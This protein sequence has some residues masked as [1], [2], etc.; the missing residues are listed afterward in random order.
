MR[1]MK[2]HHPRPTDREPTAP[3]VVWALFAV[4]ITAACQTPP[5]D[6]HG[7]AASATSAVTAP[8]PAQ[9]ETAASSPTSSTSA[10]DST[11]PSPEVP[12]CKAL[13]RK[14]TES[15]GLG[16]DEQLQMHAEDGYV[17]LLSYLDVM[18]RVRWSRISRSGGQLEQIAEV[19]R[20]GLPST[21]TSRDGAAYYTQSG[22]LFK[23]GPE[24]GASQ[25]LSESAHSPPALY[26]DHLFFVECDKKGKADYLQE[27]PVTGGPARTLAE[28]AHPPGK[29]CEYPSLVADAR[30]VIVADWKGQRVVAVSRK[31]GSQRTLLTKR[32]FPQ[33]LILEDNAVTLLSSRGLERIARDG[34]ATVELLDSEQAAAPF[35]HVTL[36]NGEYWVADWIPYM[37][38][39]HL[40]RL[41]YAGGKAQSVV[42]F[43][44]ASPVDSS[45]TDRFLAGFAVDDECVYWARTRSGGKKAELFARGK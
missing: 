24:L 16:P 33:S 10:A 41:P 14:Q 35:S 25:T 17:Y 43:S 27:I 13:G 23:L 8:T 31:D 11:V 9:P 2:N 21:L 44:Q 15:I 29:R 30:D 37:P 22:T 20:L 32:G 45:P 1:L 28:F 36:N 4:C 12:H 40:F 6:T 18:A 38:T 34:G 7:V 26:A 19:K 3:R 39:D 5:A 42:S